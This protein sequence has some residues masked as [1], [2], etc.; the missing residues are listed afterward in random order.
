MIPMEK[1]IR[2]I[3]LKNFQNPDEFKCRCGCGK[4]IKDDF[5]VSLQ[6]FVFYL[7]RIYA[8]EI[9]VQVNCGSRCAK[10]N[11]EVGGE[12]DSQHLNDCAA[13]LVFFQK[14]KDEWVQ[15]SNDDIAQLAIKTGLFTGIGW[16][17]YKKQGKNLVHLDKRDGQHVARW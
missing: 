9:K 5:L 3:T 12:P 15:I 8:T 16:M 10:H 7:A 4:N 2:K 17:Q 11:A 14:I 6:A 1:P 13:D